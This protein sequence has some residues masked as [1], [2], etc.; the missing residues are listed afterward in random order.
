MTV[1]RGTS[2][3]NDRGS[4]AARRRRKQWLLDKFGD[5]TTCTCS[6]CP[7]V[8]TFDTITVDR[9]PIAGVDGGRYVHGNIRPQCSLCASRQGADMS[10]ARRRAARVVAAAAVSVAALAG[11]SSPPA[12]ADGTGNA[13]GDVTTHWVDTPHGR[14]LCVAEKS[15]GA[16]GIGL[17]ISCDWGHLK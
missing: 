5:G 9:Y 13:P 10:H 4:A 1:R 6:T 17:G 3:T 16:T 8:L 15:V 14:V 2:N 12:A 11:C 7:T